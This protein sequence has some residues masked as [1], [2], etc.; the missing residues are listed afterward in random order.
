MENKEKNNQQ[1]TEQISDEAL[2][3][4]SGGNKVAFEEAIENTTVNQ[5]PVEG[6]GEKGLFFKFKK[7]KKFFH[8][9]HH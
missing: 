8:H 4:V 3:D 1:P 5:D 2:E 7:K 9:H 6:A